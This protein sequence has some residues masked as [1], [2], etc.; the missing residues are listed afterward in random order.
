MERYLVDYIKHL[1][2]AKQV[3]AILKFRGMLLLKDLVNNKHKKLIDY[4]EKKILKRLYEF[5]RSEFKE[6][7]LLQI[8]PVSDPVVSADFYQLVLECLDNWGSKYGETNPHYQEKRHKLMAERKLPVKNVFLNFPGPDEVLAPNDAF[9]HQ[10]IESLLQEIRTIRE[11][12]TSKLLENNVANFKTREI[13]RLFGEYQNIYQKIDNHPDKK[14]FV[15][16]RM[17]DPHLDQ[18]KDDL[19]NELIYYQ[20]FADIYLKANSQVSNQN[21]YIEL[22]NLNKNF[23]NKS[24]NI[25]PCLMPETAPKYVYEPEELHYYDNSM[26]SINKDRQD[27]VV[28]NPRP[29]SDNKITSPGKNNMKYDGDYIYDGLKIDDEDNYSYDLDNGKNRSMSAPKNNKSKP[30]VIYQTNTNFEK[31]DK[32]NN[33]TKQNQELAEAIKQLEAHKREL[34]QK[35]KDIEGE[36]S[37]RKS[38]VRSTSYISTPIKDKS[39]ANEGLLNIMRNKEEQIQNLQDKIRRIEEEHAR[40]NAPEE[41]FTVIRPSTPVDN[42]SRYRSRSNMNISAYKTEA[43]TPKH[44]RNDQYKS[45]TGG[46]EFVNQM[47]NNINKLLHKPNNRQAIKDISQVY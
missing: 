38:N 46:T 43:R 42:K 11:Q 6:N 45:E 17:V 19:L 4:V 22:K 33:M 2:K 34:S 39:Y 13:E 8:D 35:V 21:F 37:I 36:K 27:V 28:E 15:N 44:V 24:L 10:N 1:V 14:A 12:F 29:Y 30:K 9:N 25:E 5:G 23:F 32:I 26:N 7:V 31:L 41:D 20:S 16:D 18:F 40:L 47:Y 3:S